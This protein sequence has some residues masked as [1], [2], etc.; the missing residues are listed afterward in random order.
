[1]W[2]VLTSSKYTWSRKHILEVEWDTQEET[3]PLELTHRIAHI[4]C[5]IPSLSPDLS[6]D[7][8]CY[9]WFKLNC[10]INTYL[11]SS[12]GQ[13]TE[14]THSVAKWLLSDRFMSNQTA[15]SAPQMDIRKS[16]K[17]I[18]EPLSK[19]ELRQPRIFFPSGHCPETA[20]NTHVSTYLR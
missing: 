11:S 1:M 15:F 6:Y 17:H 18:I 2:H 14:A 10:F 4:C 9:Q 7:Q 16:R 3:Q 8:Q 19:F 13:S 20:T 12:A 5:H